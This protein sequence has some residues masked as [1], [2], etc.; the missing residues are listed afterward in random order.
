MTLFVWRAVVGDQ[1]GDIAAYQSSRRWRL[2][3]ERHPPRIV[4][5]GSELDELSLGGTT[6]ALRRGAYP[7]SFAG[8]GIGSGVD[9]QLP[10]VASLAH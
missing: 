10:A 1:F 9:P 8:L 5:A 7:P 4:D 2:S 3:P 6:S